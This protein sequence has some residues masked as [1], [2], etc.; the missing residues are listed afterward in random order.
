M[1]PEKL[2]DMGARELELDFD[3]KRYC[4]PFNNAAMRVAEQVYED[5][6]ER[7]EADWTVI[8]KDLLNGK[9]RAVQAVYFGAL[10]AAHKEISW[11]EFD[12]KFSMGDVPAVAEVFAKA[13]SSALPEPEEKDKNE[14]NA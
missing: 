6:F 14:K 9:F 12:E 7:P 2:T 1:N 5:A 10:H 11:E 4:V 13:V 8:L 3:G